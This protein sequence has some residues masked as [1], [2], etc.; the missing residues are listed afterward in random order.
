M[1]L[2]K[3]NMSTYVIM[4]NGSFITGLDLACTSVFRMFDPTACD[5]DSTANQMMVHVYNNIY[6]CDGGCVNDS[7]WSYLV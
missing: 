2:I 1:H 4:S 5:Y 7:D 6:N 3:P